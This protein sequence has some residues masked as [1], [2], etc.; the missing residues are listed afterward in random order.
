MCQLDREWDSNDSG[1]GKET[2]GQNTQTSVGEMRKYQRGQ[3]KQTLG[4][5]EAEISQTLMSNKAFTTSV[6]K[7][8]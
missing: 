8:S 6:E 7:L 3:E 5:R 2:K 4:V 1:A